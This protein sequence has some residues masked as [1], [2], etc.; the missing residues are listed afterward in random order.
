M[1]SGVQHQ[2]VY[3]TQHRVIT[4]GGFVK[5]GPVIFQDVAKAAGLTSWHHTAGT[6]D[7]PYI[8]E[9]KGP[10]VCLIDYDNDGWLD[11]Y[12]VNGSTLDAMNGKADGSAGGAVP[13]QPRRNVYRCDGE[14]G[15]GQRL[16]WG[17]G[18]RGGGLRQ[19]RLA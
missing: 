11:I 13:Q 10:G 18:M 14:G 7:K 4:A 15:R 3:D 12:L 19:R 5:T 16:R 17:Y 6:P 8:V 1:A 9:A 2:A